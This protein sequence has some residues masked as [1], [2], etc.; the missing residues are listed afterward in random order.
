MRRLEV[1]C[2][3]CGKKHTVRTLAAP[4]LCCSV[5]SG[6]HRLIARVHDPETGARWFAVMHGTK[7]RVFTRDA[8]TQ[9]I[10]T[11]KR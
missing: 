5:S 11:V 1:E 2:G 8:T 3:R 6:V 7:V 10:V 9:R 4:L